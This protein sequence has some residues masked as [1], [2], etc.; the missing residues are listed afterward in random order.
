MGGTKN[1][2]SQMGTWQGH[3]PGAKV[4]TIFLLEDPQTP[5]EESGASVGLQIPWALASG[6]ES[7][8]SH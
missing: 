5:G 7:P 1:W 4:W 6:L 8:M 3:W 2:T